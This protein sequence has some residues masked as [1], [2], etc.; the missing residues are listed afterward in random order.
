MFCW[1]IN[2]NRR[3]A[4]AHLKE[5]LPTNL[6]NRHARG[7][8]ATINGEVSS[9]GRATNWIKTDAIANLFVLN[10]V[11]SSRFYWA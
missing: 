9:F 5:S 6:F 10:I 2:L 7:V 11:E 3:L 8:T 4:I 1:L